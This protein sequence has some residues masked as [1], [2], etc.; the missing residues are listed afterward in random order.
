M[1]S[2]YHKWIHLLST[3]RVSASSNTQGADDS[4]VELTGF[5]RPAA[6]ELHDLSVCRS[7]GVGNPKLC[8]S[9]H[10]VDCE[11]Q[12]HQHRGINPRLSRPDGHARPET[13]YAGV[14]SAFNE[15]KAIEEPDD[16]LGASCREQQALQQEATQLLQQH[17]QGA[18]PHVRLVLSILSENLTDSQHA[19]KVDVAMYSRSWQGVLQQ[20]V[21]AV[22]LW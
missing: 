21:N 13:K 7:R 17:W 16:A 19:C 18:E 22:S 1:S 14:Q 4:A 15:L 9:D 11:L 10:D 6:K 8:I 2:L 3:K 12:P 20:M 5:A